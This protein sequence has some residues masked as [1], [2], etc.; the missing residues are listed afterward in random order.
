MND[1]HYVNSYVNGKILK[2]NVGFLI[3][4]GVGR[5]RDNEFDVPLPLRVSDD[6][7]LDYLKGPLR[8]SRTSRG[9]LVQGTLA[10]QLHTD[11]ARCLDEA[12]VQMDVPLEELYVYPPEPDAEFVVTEDG[13]LDLAPLLREEVIINV[14]QHTLCKDNCAGLCPEC[15][16]NLN[17]GPCECDSVPIDPRMAALQVLKEKMKQQEAKQGR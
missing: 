4:E 12:V 2:V 8:F 15:G 13:N 16:A 9:V 10:T 17:E 1:T 6:L 7:T 3:S 11:C 5:S 14:P